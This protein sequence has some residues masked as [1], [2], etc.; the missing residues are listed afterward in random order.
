[1]RRAIIV[2]E[3]VADK[4][5]GVV[6]Y[7]KD[8]LKLSENAALE[9]RDR[10]LKFIRSLGAPVDHPLCRF[11]RWRKA[12]YRC[13]VFERDWVIAYQTVIKGIIVRD[14]AHTAGLKE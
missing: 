11:R 4:L 7:L 6:A 2:S 3:K 10:F 14:M 13:A 1:M 9:Y 5:D 12:G 8:D